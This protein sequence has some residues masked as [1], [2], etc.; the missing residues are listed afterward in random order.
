MNGTMQT[1]PSSWVD[2]DVVAC[3]QTAVLQFP[4]KQAIV[5]KTDSILYSEL[6]ALSNCLGRK[7]NTLTDQK[8]SIIA[9]YAENPI[10]LAISLLGIL[11]A[12]ATCV[13]LDIKSPPERNKKII[14]M[15]NATALIVEDELVL[16]DSM[17][18]SI[19][20]HISLINLLSLEPESGID[21]LS[22][23]EIRHD[24]ALYFTSG[25]TGMPKGIRRS[26]KH[27]VYEAK[28]Y[29]ETLSLTCDDNLFMPLSFTYGA[30]T[31]HSL[32]AL[33]LGA[34]LYATA[35][36]ELSSAD[37]L[38]FCTTHKISIFYG[39]P[40]LFRNLCKVIDAVSRPSSIRC[41]SLTGEALKK[42]DIKL[43]NQ[44]WD[45]SGDI[46]LNSLGSTECGAYCHFLIDHKTLIS[47]QDIP[48]GFPVNG[49]DVAICDV[50]G[51][52][53]QANETGE[54]VVSSEYLSNGYWQDDELTK[55]KFK[56]NPENNEMTFYTGDHGYKDDD[57]RVFISHRTD[58]QIK[59]RGYRVDI[60][61]IESVLIQHSDISQSLV[62]ATKNQLNETILTAYL[63]GD[64]NL[65]AIDINELNRFLM[66]Q[67]PL[68]MIPVD[69]FILDKIPL[70]ERG[71]V[72]R[73]SLSPNTAK[74]LKSVHSKSPLIL[75]TESQ[76]TSIWKSVLKH[77]Q[78]SLTDSF[79]A[80]GGD[81]LQA[82]EL[83]IEVDSMFDRTLLLTQLHEAPTIEL[84]AVFLHKDV[85]PARIISHN[86]SKSE[87][88]LIGLPNISCDTDNLRQLLSELE[89]EFKGYGFELPLFEQAIDLEDVAL[90]CADLIQEKFS[91]KPIYLIGYSFGGVLA[92]ETARQLISRNCNIQYLFILD[93]TFHYKRS[94]NTMQ[95]M[96][97]MIS[98]FIVFNYDDKWEYFKFKLFKTQNRIKN[99]VV[100]TPIQKKSSAVFK[101]GG[102]RIQSNMFLKNAS[103]QY[104][105]G[106][107]DVKLV[108]F[109]SRKRAF[110]IKYDAALWKSSV[111]QSIETII[112]PVFKHGGLLKK[113]YLNILIEHLRN[114]N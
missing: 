42:D 103:R 23:T 62:Q 32:A 113:K 88:I 112:I 4:D 82:M 87:K 38:M 78:F 46:L 2:R 49:K 94:Y 16:D 99:R 96:K 47:T 66:K 93:S 34:S 67:L 57:G 5:T 72:D 102:K 91:T 41:M 37:M 85:T 33:F 53:V 111:K 31:K 86:N 18:V 24:M 39:T 104:H 74:A 6:D 44:Y 25:T 79:F 7:I 95:R 48:V 19:P 114:H 56:L 14:E 77:D 108:L 73:K 90:I 81:S 22:D 71:K 8:Q 40:S 17:K 52:E 11:K 59:I 100:N 89:S 75:Q 26:H 69:Y 58:S 106:S 13:F 28:L 63:V 10:S 70:N 92:F 97:F 36:G 9:V 76:L 65:D 50:D 20:D 83:S 29:A 15:T 98:N 54:I 3:F 12:N 51:L 21:C 84:L 110:K 109:R 80:V 60:G 68:H 27:A 35:P 55:K 43:F 30:S 101:K 1:D 61:E 64:A 105:P 45:K 107:I